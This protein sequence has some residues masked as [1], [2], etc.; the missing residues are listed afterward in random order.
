MEL[1]DLITIF[2]KV[3][4]PE[5]KGQINAQT[6]FKELEEWSSLSAFTIVE[7]INENFSV[8]IRGIQLRK[9]N[10]IEELFNLLNAK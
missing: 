5:G 2:N 7:L 1:K 3:L 4:N 6:E 8:R 9:C 10:N